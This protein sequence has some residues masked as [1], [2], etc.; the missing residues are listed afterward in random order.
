MILTQTE[1]EP[2]DAPENSSYVLSQLQYRIYLSHDINLKYALSD[3]P[4]T[5][6]LCKE[7]AHAL[8]SFQYVFPVTGD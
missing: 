7:N 2:T 5:P 3:D 8:A 1:I 6:V 4:D